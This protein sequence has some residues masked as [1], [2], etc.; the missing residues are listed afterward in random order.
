M[1]YHCRRSKSFVLTTPVSTKTC[2]ISTSPPA[3][4][5]P[6]N[7]ITTSCDILPSFIPANSLLNGSMTIEWNKLYKAWGE[8]NSTMLFREQFR[9][10]GCQNWDIETKKRSDGFARRLVPRRKRTVCSVSNTDINNQG[11]DHNTRKKCSNVVSAWH[12]FILKI[13]EKL[14]I[15]EQD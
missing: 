15:F 11:S 2:L 3:L 8:E 9:V 7:N 12:M 14:G 1:N 13:R 10:V 6:E 4:R 5:K